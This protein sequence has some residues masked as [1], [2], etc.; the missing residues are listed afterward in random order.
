MKM[1]Q[2][3][4]VKTQIILTFKQIRLRIMNQ[5]IMVVNLQAMKLILIVNKL[6]TMIQL[7]IKRQIIILVKLKL[8]LMMK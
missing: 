1:K 7:K 8:Q 2:I 6:L 3:H 5:L 4:L